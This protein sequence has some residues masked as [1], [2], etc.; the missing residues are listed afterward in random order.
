MDWQLPPYHSLRLSPKIFQAV[1]WRRTFVPTWVTCQISV[2]T[3]MSWRYTLPRTVTRVSDYGLTDNRAKVG[4]LLRLPK[5][6]AVFP[7]APRRLS[8]EDETDIQHCMTPWIHMPCLI[9]RPLPLPLLISIILSG[10]LTTPL[11]LMIEASFPLAHTGPLIG[12]Y[13]STKGSRLMVMFT[14]IHQTLLW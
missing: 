13:H 9:C 8:R 4:T 5:P 6:S 3:R 7:S 11:V 14:R 12:L 2:I 10:H 1:T